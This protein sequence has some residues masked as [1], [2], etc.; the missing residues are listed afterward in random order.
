MAKIKGVNGAWCIKIGSNHIVGT[1]EASMNEE[2]ILEDVTTLTDV[3]RVDES[4]GEPFERARD[5][6]ACGDED[7]GAGC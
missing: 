7:G 2:A 1:T 4:L 6:D 5:P 3:G